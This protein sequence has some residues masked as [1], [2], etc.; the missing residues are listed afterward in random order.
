MELHNTKIYNRIGDEPT[1]KP[2][3]EPDF[4]CLNLNYLNIPKGFKNFLN[5]IHSVLLK[6]ILYIT[7][8]VRI[9]ELGLQLVA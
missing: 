1:P 2:E 8:L 6:I 7:G 5:H 9:L 4:D 3:P